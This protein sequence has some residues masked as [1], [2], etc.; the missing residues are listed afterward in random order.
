[1]GQ[2]R[3]QLV[4]GVEVESHFIGLWTWR[5]GGYE[6]GWSKSLWLTRGPIDGAHDVVSGCA[7]LK[8]AVAYSVGFC[9]GVGA[10]QHGLDSMA[11]LK[12]MGA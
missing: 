5:F 11:A 10:T 6:W 1:M 12:G 8:I 9:D 2:R 4:F 3:K 7:C